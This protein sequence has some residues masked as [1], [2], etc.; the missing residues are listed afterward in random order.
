MSDAPNDERLETLE[1]EL[2]TLRNRIDEIEG[3][4]WAQQ[5]KQAYAT[6]LHAAQQAAR[7]VIKNKMASVSQGGPS[8]AYASTEQIV[9]H[10]KEALEPHGLSVTPVGGTMVLLGNSPI[11][12]ASW[13][14][15]HVGGHSVRYDGSWP[16]HAVG[17]RTIDRAM[18]SAKTMA[19]GY[20][21]RDL[22]MLPRDE[23]DDM[24]SGKGHARPA[25][26]SGPRKNWRSQNAAPATPA[27][28]PPRTE[29][30]PPASAA[31][32]P[33]SDR[34][35]EGIKRIR[36]AG[37]DAIDKVRSWVADQETWLK[38]DPTECPW[39]VA[40][41]QALLDAFHARA[42]ELGR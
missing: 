18:G 41:I 15:M 22:L 20:F 12:N 35:V 24:D 34:A 1:F 3:G 5:A 26:T 13:E 29:A 23:A 40:E 6:A 8:Y 37:P 32:A 27:E 9:A 30:A 7:A 28:P 11:L 10:A 16:I 36:A 25:P 17:A 2:R 38:S 31:R 14:V 4:T 39:T 42:K 19:Y 21:L 33:M